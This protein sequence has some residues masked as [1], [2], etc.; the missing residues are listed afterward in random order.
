M[1][2]STRS[3]FRVSVADLLG[4]PG[5]RR[6]V[7]IVADVDWHLELS[8]I[9]PRLEADLVLES[10][11]GGVLVK[12]PV[13]TTVAHTCHRCLTDWEEELAVDVADVMGLDGVDGGDGYPLDDEVADLEQPIRDRLLLET[14]LL[15]A[16]RE[17]CLGLCAVC[18]A[19]LNT[20]SCPGHD[21][22]T[23]SPF[24]SLRDLLT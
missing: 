14:P 20:G 16:C 23:T 13:S 3:G 12:G 21:E 19:D 7:P 4:D 15:P 11:A 6:N 5:R 17:G 8:R 18:G 2:G 9:G 22:E 1:R 10:T 24:A